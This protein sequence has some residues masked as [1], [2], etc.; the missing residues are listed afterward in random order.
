MT[1]PNNIGVSRHLEE[2]LVLKIFF[3][4]VSDEVTEAQREKG[5]N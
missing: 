5:L 4:S 3:F 2:N 1:E